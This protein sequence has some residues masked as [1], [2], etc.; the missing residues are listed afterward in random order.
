MYGIFVKWKCGGISVNIYHG[1]DVVVEKPEIL[2]SSRLL[3]FGTGFY[4]TS[5]KNKRFADHK[6]L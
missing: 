5:K 4:T 1:S 2:Q 3:D 6:T